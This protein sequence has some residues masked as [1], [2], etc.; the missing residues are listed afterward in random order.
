MMMEP[1]DDRMRE[2]VS[3]TK[4]ALRQRMRGLRASMPQAAFDERSERIRDAVLAMEEVVAA[5]RVGLFWPISSKR[6]LDLRPLDAALRDRNK[7]LYYPFMDPKENGAFET[8][9]RPVP[10]P[11]ELR[12]RGRGFAEPDPCREAARHG[13][14]DVIVVPALAADPRGHRLGYGGG[15]YDATLPDFCP[16][17]L[18]VAVLFDFQ[19]V[20]ELPLVETDIPCQVVVTDARILDCRNL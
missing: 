16:P 4:Q 14:L 12:E 3:Q 11:S 15:V 1:S 10:H 8:G 18:A 5:R 17:A 9:F 7:E 13:E 19:V 6:E 2:F 20:V